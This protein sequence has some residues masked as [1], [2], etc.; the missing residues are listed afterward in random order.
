MD[1]EPCR[2]HRTGLAVLLL[3]PQILAA[4]NQRSLLLRTD[5]AVADSAW[6]TGFRRTMASAAMTDV[7]LLWPGAQVVQGQA[8]VAMLLTVLQGLGNVTHALLEQAPD[9]IRM[10][11]QPI[12]ADLSLDSTLG[13]T[14][15]VTVSSSAVSK[16][17]VIGRYIAAWRR[18]EAGAATPWRLAALMLTDASG[19]DNTPRITDL[20]LELL[21]AAAQGST[22]PFVSADLAFARLA[23]DSGAAIAFERWAAPDAH[24]FAGGGLLVQG[25][26]A[27]GTV[28]SA[29]ASW[30][31][32]PVAAG[33]SGDGSMGWT[34]GEAVITSADGHSGPSKYLT[35]WKRQAN[36]EIR[37]LTDGGNGRPA[38]P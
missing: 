21:P 5:R 3:L 6:S 37:F 8:N 30:K 25:P 35:I 12:G 31:W 34:A 10:T 14:W 7:V 23:L 18:D 32:H 24:T 4:Q 1:P 26:A 11:W 29:P 38:A 20:P 13:A 28:V 22:A 9:S 2:W 17:P 19:D 15:G 36:G 33:T 27:I 16:A